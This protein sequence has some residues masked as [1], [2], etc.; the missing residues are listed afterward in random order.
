M[1]GRILQPDPSQRSVTYSFRYHRRP[2]WPRRQRTP[3]DAQDING[4][5]DAMH[6]SLHKSDSSSPLHA[7][8]L[9]LTKW[10]LYQRALFATLTITFVS[11]G[12][13]RWC[14]GVVSP[15][16]VLCWHDFCL[17]TSRHRFIIIARPPDLVSPLTGP[18]HNGDSLHMYKLQAQA[19]CAEFRKVP[20]KST[21]GGQSAIDRDLEKGVPRS[22]LTYPGVY[23]KRRWNLMLQIRHC[24]GSTIRMARCVLCARGRLFV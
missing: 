14:P 7:S 22:E 17:R 10:L 12:G 5:S 9:Y 15:V 23:V 21:E 6:F 8:A 13:L 11:P 20:T 2:L 4:T 19:G 18:L 1:R 16:P 3:G 24:R